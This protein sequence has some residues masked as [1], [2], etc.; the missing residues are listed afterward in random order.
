MLKFDFWLSLYSKN[1]YLLILLQFLQNKIIWS[2]CNGKTI[3]IHLK[4]SKSLPV[5]FNDFN[6]ST[7]LCLIVF[8]ICLFALLMLRSRSSI[9]SV[10]IVLFS[11]GKLGILV[12]IVTLLLPSLLSF[13]KLFQNPAFASPRSIKLVHRLLLVLY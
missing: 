2:I 12:L 8:L 5:M 13:C 11:L 10:V 3:Y 7:R 6:F 1:I 9:L 4:A